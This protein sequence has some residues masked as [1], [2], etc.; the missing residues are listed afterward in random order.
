MS[1]RETLECE[2]NQ[3]NFKAS[4]LNEQSR[5]NWNVRGNESHVKATECKL[6]GN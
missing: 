3:S 5:K 1:K 6:M 2:G 4:D